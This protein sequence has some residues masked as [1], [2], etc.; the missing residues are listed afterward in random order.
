MLVLTGE[1]PRDIDALHAGR[2]VVLV[3]VADDDEAARG[4]AVLDGGG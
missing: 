1:P 4:G 2:V 3:D